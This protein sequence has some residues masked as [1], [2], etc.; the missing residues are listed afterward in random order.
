MAGMRESALGS[1]SFHSKYDADLARQLKVIAQIKENDKISVDN[2]TIR[3]DPPTHLQSFRR[4]FYGD[5]RDRSLTVVQEVINCMFARIQHHMHPVGDDDGGP[6]PCRLSRRGLEALSQAT[7]GLKN[8]E[9]TYADDARTISVIQ[10]LLEDIEDFI[11]AA[12]GGRGAAG[13]KGPS[14]GPV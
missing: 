10:Q 14:R 6:G 8:L 1:L 13:C 11:D 4:F 7:R 12:P 5:N 9:A 3:I 2:G